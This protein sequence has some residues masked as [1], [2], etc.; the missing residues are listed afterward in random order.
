[1]AKVTF[2]GHSAVE[3]QGSTHSVLIDPFISENPVAQVAP[4]DVHPSAI[5]LTH[6]HFDHLGDAISIS[7]ANEIPIVAPFELAIF[8]GE[9]GAHEAVD[10]NPGGRRKFDF[11]EVH[12]TKAFHSSSFE[13]RYLGHACGIV[14]TTDDGKVIYH[15]G[16]TELFGDMELIARFNA[17]DL[18]LLPIGGNWNMTPMEAMEAVRLLKPK[19]VVPIHYD[20]FPVIEQDAEAFKAAVE[21]ETEVKVVILKPGESYEL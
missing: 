6:G 20:T 8:C 14:F 12:F 7:Q 13:G 17:I 11:G 19:A 21:A 9:Q 2:I 10:M 18:A 1:M 16:D 3:V 15:S 4:E 5:L